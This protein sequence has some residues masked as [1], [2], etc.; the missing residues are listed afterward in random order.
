MAKKKC[1]DLYYIEKN[2]S[3]V[4]PKDLVALNVCIE[5]RRG[6]IGKDWQPPEYVITKRKKWPDWIG[7][8]EPLASTRA[9]TVLHEYIDPA[10]EILPWV[11]E[12]EHVYS[13][14]NPLHRVP[15]SHWSCKESSKYGFSFANADVL[16]IDC[17]DAPDIF[18]L[19]GYD[20]KTFVSDRLA[21]ASVKAGLTGVAFVNPLIRS[22]SLAFRK[23]DFGS[24]GT[25]F[26]ES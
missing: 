19:E 7:F 16:T 22:L 21:V 15:I 25:G 4:M 3:D 23:I 8:L 10:C 17:D 6:R 18:K 2:F 24:A 1:W 13:I 20:G 5:L 11:N 9:L 14:L 26:I 12:G